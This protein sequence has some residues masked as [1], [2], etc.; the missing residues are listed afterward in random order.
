M[1]SRWPF[2]L[3]MV[4]PSLSIG[5]ASFLVV[6]EG[7]WLATRN[8]AFRSLYLFWAEVF[9]IAFVVGAVCGVALSGQAEVEWL[10]LSAI[11][12]EAACVAVMV[13]GWRKVGPGLHMAAT[14]AAAMA[15]PVFAAWI[16]A[17]S[18]DA[19][20]PGRFT[21]T[22]LAAYLATALLVGAASAL[23][24]LRNGPA[25]ECCTAL[26]MAIGMFAI[27]APLLL[28]AGDRP[29]RVREPGAMPAAVEA[30][31]IV[32]CLGVLALGAW[33]VWLLW[34]TRGPEYSLGY[35]RAVVAMGPTGIV[36]VLAVALVGQADAPALTPLTLTICTL[37][38]VAGALVILRATAK[39]PRV[40]EE[41][42]A[43]ATAT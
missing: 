34:R 38:S 24:L 20:F 27:V 42:L 33:G 6:L 15:A 18:P 17:A 21:L 25:V 7:L 9:G 36:L 30:V 40:P 5:L 41:P 16:A 35:L 43:P 26:H 1:F 11:V 39:G 28:L 14:T 19:P 12:V 3:P 31:G 2:A 8:E 4:F 13:F 32:V 22:L 10:G 23:R 37:V 29:G